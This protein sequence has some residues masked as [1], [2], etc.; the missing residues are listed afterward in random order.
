MAPRAIWEEVTV[1]VTPSLQNGSYRPGKPLFDQRPDICPRVAL[2]KSCR[3]SSPLLRRSVSPAAT[4]PTVVPGHIPSLT[5][6]YASLRSSVTPACVT[7][8]RDARDP[9]RASNRTPPN[10]PDIL[11]SVPLRLGYPLFGFLVPASISTRCRRHY[12]L[13]STASRVP[14]TPLEHP[15][16]SV[17]TLLPSGRMCVNRRKRR[18]L[19]AK[20]ALPCPPRSSG[21]CPPLCYQASPALNPQYYP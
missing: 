3:D 1:E 13:S 19:R 21:F 8:C 9:P 14:T 6:L 4:P 16:L 12:R 20:S 5:P 7:D 11:W 15:G 2:A 10:L 18:V 17:Q